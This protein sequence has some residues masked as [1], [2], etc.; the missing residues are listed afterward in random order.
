LAALAALGLGAIGLHLARAS[1]AEGTGPTASTLDDAFSAWSAG[2]LGLFLVG[3]AAGLYVSPS[4][5]IAVATATVALGYA[6]AWSVDALLAD[7]GEDAGEVISGGLFFAPVAAAVGV[8]AG[9]TGSA[10]GRLKARK[11]DSLRGPTNLPSDSVR[12]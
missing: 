5:P 2:L 6:V 10:A 12:R 4:R 11:R 9:A 8:L 1:R 7:S 3:V